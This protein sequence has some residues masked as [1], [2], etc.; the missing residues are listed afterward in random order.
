MTHDPFYDL[1][2]IRSDPEIV[3]G[4]TALVTIDMQYL[5]AHRDGWWAGW[6]K[7]RPGGVSRAQVVGY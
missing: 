6:L 4:K 2:P 1:F 3:S 7:R 5:D